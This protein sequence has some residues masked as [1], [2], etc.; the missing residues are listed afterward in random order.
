MLYAKTVFGTRSLPLSIFYSYST[1]P[2][3]PLLSVQHSLPC[4]N[5]NIYMYHTHSKIT[6]SSGS[7]RN[8]LYT[9]DRHFLHHVIGTTT[10][11]CGAHQ[12][13]TKKSACTSLLDSTTRDHAAYRYPMLW[14][15]CLLQAPF[16]DTL[17]GR[18]TGREENRCYLPFHQVTLNILCCPAEVPI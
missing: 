3:V 6:T 17:A 14:L 13:C 18:N 10:S 5:Y 16:T 11:M 9:P 7:T 2:P 8:E 15:A 12:L 4:Y 1:T